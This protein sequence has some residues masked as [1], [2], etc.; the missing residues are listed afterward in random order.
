MAARAFGEAAEADPRNGQRWI[1]LAHAE[2]MSER[3]ARAR[4]AFARLAA[5][6][7]RDP[8]PLVE[9]GFTHELERNYDRALVTYRRA[10]AL[11]PEDPYPYR[12]LG[13]RLLRWDRAADAIAPL[14][15]ALALDE[16]D[17]DAHAETVKALALAR[18]H[19][20]DE[21]G[22]EAQ[23]RRGLRDDPANVGLRLGLAAL[24][25]RSQRYAGALAEYDVV[26]E[27]HPR[28]A[29]AHVG[30]G[31]LLHEIGREDEAEAAFER[32]ASV[33]DQPERYLRRLAEYR[34]L[35]ARG[36]TPAPDAADGSTSVDPTTE[37]TTEATTGLATPVDPLEPIDSNAPA[38]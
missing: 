31:I 13:A 34:A 5:L 3:P 10:I 23:F 37:A 29:P 30:R 17:D 2:L 15:R 35:R 26:L 27:A 4:A 38:E 24:L 16:A 25:I 28:F 8:R 36:P 22:S 18:F 9:I 6:R 20:G 7:P 12:V 32:A 19:A 1:A 21:E 33:A 11:A 14:E